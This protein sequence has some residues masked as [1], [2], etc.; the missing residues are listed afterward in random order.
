MD[1]E[2]KETLIKA[3]DNKPLYD[4]LAVITPFAAQ[5]RLIQTLLIEKLGEDACHK[6][7]VGTVHAL[8]GAEK[9]II[10]FSSVNDESDPQVFMNLNGKH[11]MLNVALTRAKHAFV[12]IGNMRV[13]QSHLNTPSGKLGRMLFGNPNYALDS[14]FLYASNF[15]YSNE[16]YKRI[17]SLEM[18][19][20]L[21]KRCFNIAKS[22]LII[23]SPF[24]SIKAIEADQLIPLMQQAVDRG[25]KVTI[26]TD[27]KFDKTE[28]GTIKKNSAIGR[29]A[30]AATKAELKEVAGI[31]NKTIGID[32]EILIE[33]SFNWLSAVRDE[34]SPYHRHEVSVVLKGTQEVK[35][36]FERLKRRFGL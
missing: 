3:Y 12:V 33:G 34:K 28:N 23:C 10:L 13:F 9:P 32:G 1:T 31:H 15:V 25:V 30:I 16:K 18:H 14:S 7:V 29:K 20:R 36:D 35:K 19:V 2:P 6:L 21:L 5:K 27:S 26:L 8:Q 17:T 24:I 22:E 11:N 4:I